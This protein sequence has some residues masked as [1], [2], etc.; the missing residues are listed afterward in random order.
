MTLVSVLAERRRSHRQDLEA[1][2][3]VPWPALTILGTIATLFAT[4]L[5]IKGM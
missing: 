2:G 4:A 5:A 1:V 3:W